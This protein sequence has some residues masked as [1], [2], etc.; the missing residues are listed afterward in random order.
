MSGPK[1]DEIEL[2]EEEIER[3]RIRYEEK[4]R[5][6]KERILREKE[7]KHQ[8]EIQRREEKQRKLAEDAQTLREERIREEEVRMREE[9]RVDDY[10]RRM[11]ESR[12]AFQK[13][14]EEV[15]IKEFEEALAEYEAVAELSEKPLREYSF[16]RETAKQ[17]I[18]EMREAVECI[19][20]MS[21]QSICRN[22]VSS[23]IDE[24]IEGMGYHILAEKQTKGQHHAVSKLYQYDE[25]TVI[26]VLDVDGQFTMEIAAVDQTDRM[27]TEREKK[28]LT[29]SM[30]L[31]CKDYEKIKDCLEQTDEI[32][33]KPVFH[34]PVQEKYARIINR[35]GYTGKK[36]TKDKGRSADYMMEAGSE[37]AAISQKH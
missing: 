21:I 3:Q 6:K 10:D 5:R 31:F 13:Q 26:H 23:L 1:C 15:L 18:A 12:E 7:R 24:T 14:Q 22:R 20:Y 19:K 16:Q 34:M 11:K 27:P 36:G 4:L 17:E 29:D 9:I 2:S 25:N 28:M 33:I 35:E 32:V 37:I 8:E 30:T